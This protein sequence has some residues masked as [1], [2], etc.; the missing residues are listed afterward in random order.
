LIMAPS[1]SKKKKKSKKAAMKQNA[2]N[3]ESKLLASLE[4]L[5]LNMQNRGLGFRPEYCSGKGRVCVATRDFS[6]GE[7]VLEE[8]AFVH[9]TENMEQCLECDS[10]DHQLSKCPAVLNKNISYPSYLLK[11]EQ[12]IIGYLAELKG[13][14]S[15]DKARVWVKCLW[16]W[17]KDPTSLD[18]L[19]ALTAPPENLARCIKSVKAAR[20]QLPYLLPE[21]LSTMQ[22]AEILAILNT[23][24]HEL[25]GLQGVGVFT[26]ACLLEHS[27]VPNLSFT[28]HNT[29]IR[30]TAL[31]PVSAGERISIDY[32][33]NYYR[34]T[35][36]RRKDLKETYGFVCNC[37]LCGGCVPDKCRAFKCPHC[38]SAATATSP[39]PL[40]LPEQ[41]PGLETCSTVGQLRS[42]GFVCPFGTG[43]GKGAKWQCL[44]CSHQLVVD[45]IRACVESEAAMKDA[46]A[47]SIEELEELVD[48]SLMHPT[49][50]QVFW[51]LEEVAQS[52]VLPD[53]GQQAGEVDL[54]NKIWQNILFCVETVLPQYHH[55]KIIYFDRL[56][57]TKISMGNIEGAR[58]A[59]QQAFEMSTTCCGAD[60]PSTLQIKLLS[61]NP[62][63]T[64]QELLLAYTF[65]NIPAELQNMNSPSVVDVNQVK[66]KCEDDTHNG[67]EDL[68]AEAV[69][70]DR[71]SS[72]GSIT[73][74]NNI[75]MDDDD[76]QNSDDALPVTA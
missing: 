24:G 74:E 8:K 45:E 25:E 46:E 1:K 26:T 47:N 48:N 59:Y 51:C 43:D 2:E 12:E 41:I 60:H 49:H 54:T 55:E 44:I 52:L 36:E 20:K 35:V 38:E 15:E 37:E 3:E 53:E 13:V 71:A 65:E 58:I 5:S 61:E 30:L 32:G 34:P 67:L 29:S 57:Q 64:M 73:G 17:G 72:F 39:S 63:K 21:S 6:L 19:L 31:Q 76:D 11:H 66:F 69:V 28:T 42:T 27:C 22:A 50:H 10:F 40:N 33:N 23:N 7:V 56:A 16:R 9:G 62:P 14:Q 18:P 75:S 4:G 70:Q 68:Q